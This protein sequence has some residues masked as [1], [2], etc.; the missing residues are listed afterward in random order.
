[1]NIQLKTLAFAWVLMWGI[2]HIIVALVAP[3]I[4]ASQHF[5]PP[6]IVVGIAV[7]VSA[8]LYLATADAITGEVLVVDAGYSLK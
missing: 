8:F 1:M 3:D 4:G 6:T 7:V 2:A 5:D